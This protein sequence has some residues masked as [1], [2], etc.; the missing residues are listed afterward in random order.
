MSMG[1]KNRG[2]TYHLICRYEE[3]FMDLTKSLKLKPNKESGLNFIKVNFRIDTIACE[4]SKRKTI[5][6]C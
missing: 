4:G 5:T 3:T 1:I 2:E 6:I